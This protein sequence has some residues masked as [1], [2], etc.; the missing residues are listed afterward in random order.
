MPRGWAGKPMGTR[1]YC[2]HS[3]VAGAAAGWLV[4]S[5]YCGWVGVC[6]AC[7]AE[8]GLPVPQGVPWAMC[9]EHWALVQSGQYRCVDG[10]VV[11]VEFEEVLH[12]GTCGEQ[13]EVAGVVPVE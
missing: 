7:L 10:Y 4:C 13:H 1:Q 2:G 3:K 6:R 11:P 8:W 12:D 9:P 5:Q